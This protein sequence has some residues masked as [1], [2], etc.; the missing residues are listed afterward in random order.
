MANPSRRSRRPSNSARYPRQL[1]LMTDDAQDAAVRA[2]A[3]ATNASI[4]QVMRDAIRAGL[5]VI[6]RRAIEDGSISS[7]VA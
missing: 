7:A 5:P 1:V 2:F 4:N 3:E 6:T